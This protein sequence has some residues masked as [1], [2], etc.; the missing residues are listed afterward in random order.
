MPPSAYKVLKAFAGEKEIQRQH[1]SARRKKAATKEQ[2]RRHR[3]GSSL[4]VVDHNGF[5]IQLTGRSTITILIIHGGTHQHQ[6]TN[7]G[8]HSN[9]TSGTST[10]RTFPCL[11]QNLAPCFLVSRVEKIYKNTKISQDKERN[12]PSI[13]TKETKEKHKQAKTKHQTDISLCFPPSTQLFRGQHL[14]VQGQAV[15]HDVVLRLLVH[16][17]L[18]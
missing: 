9:G 17:D 12:G 3:R 11:V 14:P 7:L 16:D 10:Q 2:Q 1:A 18:N 15:R 8:K 5:S 6:S 13:S 4:I